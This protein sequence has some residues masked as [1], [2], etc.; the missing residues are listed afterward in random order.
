MRNAAGHRGQTASSELRSIRLRFPIASLL[1]PSLLTALPLSPQGGD[2][3]IQETMSNDASVAQFLPKDAPLSTFR[4]MTASRLG[5]A[6]TGQSG[7]ANGGGDKAAGGRGK[8]G[9]AKAEVDDPVFAFSCVFRAGRSGGL[10]DHNSVLFDVDVPG[11]KMGVGT[12]N[13]HW[14]QL[15]P[16]ALLSTPW[17]NHSK[18]THHPDGDI[19]VTGQPLP[20]I[21]AMVAVCVEAHRSLFPGV[22][23]AGCAG[24]LSGGQ[25]HQK[26]HFD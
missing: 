16:Q 1:H 21:D 4:V 24:I 23:V 22:P 12:S 10:T 9:R 14:Y 18:Y 2:W 20:E 25:V 19:P 15:G 3:I 17:L 11:K 26:R 8:A 13:M 6:S 5:V 7:K